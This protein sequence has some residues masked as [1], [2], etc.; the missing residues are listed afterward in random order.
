MDPAGGSSAVP[1]DNNPMLHGRLRRQELL[2]KLKKTKILLLLLKT[3]RLKTRCLAHIVHAA[4]L[5]Y[6]IF[7]I[8]RHAQTINRWAEITILRLYPFYTINALPHIG[9]AARKKS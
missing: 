9:I 6:N 8:V 4:V 2:K 1:G 5:K 7:Q 3:R